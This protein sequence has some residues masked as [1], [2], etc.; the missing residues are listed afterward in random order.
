MAGIASLLRCLIRLEA[1]M[2]GSRVRQLSCSVMHPTLYKGNLHTGREQAAKFNTGPFIL[3][4]ATSLRK[5]Q[6]SAS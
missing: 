4:I 1:E 2:S 6:S 5:L 3:S